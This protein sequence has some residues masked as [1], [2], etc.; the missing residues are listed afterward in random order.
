MT[1]GDYLEFIRDG[2][3]ARHALWSDAGWSWLATANVDAPKY[4]MR[5][6]DDWCVRVMDNVASVAA[7]SSCLSR[8]LSRSGGV[9]DVRWQA[10]ADRIRV[11][12]CRGLG[13]GARGHATLSVGGR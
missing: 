2:G 8:L 12:S 1:N 3:Y 6:G 9:R 7:R 13:R 10:P 4:W 5:D 11:G